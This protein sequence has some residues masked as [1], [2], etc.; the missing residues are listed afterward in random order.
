M[1]NEEKTKDLPTLEKQRK[2]AAALA[3]PDTAAATHS[4]TMEEIGGGGDIKEDLSSSLA[5]F[6]VD[7]QKEA[8]FLDVGGNTTKQR[9]H[10]ALY[11]S[12]QANPKIRLSLDS[13]IK[14]ENVD[15]VIVLSPFLYRLQ[16]LFP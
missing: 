14:I 9:C 2:K 15:T 5:F 1:S 4:K 6:V 7:W 13:T 10:V 16:S 3:M 12:F 11:Y 8:I